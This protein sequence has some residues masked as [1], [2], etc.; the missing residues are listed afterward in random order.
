ME[1]NIW[2]DKFRTFQVSGS[3]TCGESRKTW[4]KI[5][6]KNTKKKENS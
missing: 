6:R 1:E 2:F 3:F 5:M 4:N